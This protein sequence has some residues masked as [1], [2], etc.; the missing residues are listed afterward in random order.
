MALAN[1]CHDGNITYDESWFR[2]RIGCEAQ[3]DDG[4]RKPLDARANRPALAAY[5]QASVRNS[6][7]KRKA[8]RRNRGY[9]EIHQW[10]GEMVSTRGWRRSV[11]HR[12]R[13]VGAVKTARIVE[14]G[15]MFSALTAWAFAVIALFL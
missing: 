14:I 5:E 11:Q 1:G 15:A 10:C 7:G 12:S 9:E 6:E 8:F 4:S 2:S 13:Q 3:G